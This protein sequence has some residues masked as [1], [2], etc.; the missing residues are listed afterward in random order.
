MICPMTRLHM[1][2]AP[3]PTPVSRGLGSPRYHT[4]LEGMAAPSLRYTGAHPAHIPANAFA[5]FTGALTARVMRRACECTRSKSYD[6]SACHDRLLVHLA[7]CLPSGRPT[8]DYDPTELSCVLDMRGKLLP[9]GER[10]LHVNVEIMPD[11]WA[12][13]HS[14]CLLPQVSQMRRRAWHRRRPPP[15]RARKQA[16][17]PAA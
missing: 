17:R 6:G 1:P 14:S 8:L 13:T 16:P 9:L 2:A 12:R 10:A 7:Y 5:A 3:P 4:G 15:P 11:V